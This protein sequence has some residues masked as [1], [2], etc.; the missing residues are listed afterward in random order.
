MKPYPEYKESGVEWLGKIPSHWNITRLKNSIIGSI[1]GI[2]GN[3]PG[4]ENDIP[5][6]RVADFNRSNFTIDTGN[7]TL[8]SVELKDR[9]NRILEHG[10]L[11]IEKSGGGDLQPV[12]TV[13][14]FDHDFDA[15]TSNF[16]A[17]MPI[18]N[19]FI[20]RFLCY[21][22]AHLYSTKVNTRSIK[23]TTGIQNIDQE[24]YLNENVCIPSKS[25]QCTIAA[26]LDRETSRIDTL[27]AKKQRQIELLQEKRAALISHVVTKGL[28]P[29]VRMKDSGVEWLGDVPEYWEVKKIRR[30]FNVINGSTPSSSNPE[31]WDGEINWVT[32]DDLG[33][34][35]NDTIY[36]TRRKITVS[37]YESC[38]TTL[39]PVGCIVLSTR[40]PI[41]HLALTGVP[42]CSNQG[43]R[44][45]ALRNEQ[46]NTK[47]FYYLL[48]VARPELEG[49]GQGST[50]KELSRTNLE[51]VEISYPPIDEQG[52]IVRCLDEECNKID[53]L[54][55][56]IKIS[57]EK[58]REYRTALISAA[59]TGKIDV[60]EGI[61]DE[62]I[63]IAAEP[64]V[65]YGE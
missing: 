1:N 7:L 20:S 17:R 16:I 11:L 19:N 12:G 41:G 5:C 34:L 36:E 53:S 44:L 59:V 63:R 60:R 58:L 57:I 24:A 62:Q 26:F 4:D 10:D 45:L 55:K 47:Y 40:A 43:C 30:V 61:K 49:L 42:L 28:D 21:I 23:Q 48:F 38:G 2:W 25:D 37:G 14:L 13:V 32:P 3:E 27:I 46:N 18:R 31:Y 22:Y 35:E 33:L 8:R 50:F 29:D 51:N 56:K 9:R 65:E 15:V 52:D 64:R 54:I 6:I 39:V